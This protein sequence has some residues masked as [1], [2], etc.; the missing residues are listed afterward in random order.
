L[1]IFGR[2]PEERQALREWAGSRI[3]NVGKDG[4]DPGAQCAAVFRGERLAAVVLFHDW[5][6]M[7]R[8]LQCSMAADTPLWAS[9]E[10]L[11]GLLA[12]AFITAGANKLWTAMPHTS[13]RAIR[14][15][16]GI[17]MRREA[18]LRHH[19]GPKVHAVICSMLRDEWAR[20]R[21]RA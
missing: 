1:I 15:N 11:R 14:F 7:A 18:V 9:R 17:G 12:Y 5:Q 20:S 3:P 6:P 16:L 21:W 8:T 4:F 10:A 19:F 2:T 13:E